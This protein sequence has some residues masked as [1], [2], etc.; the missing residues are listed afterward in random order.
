MTTFDFGDGNG[1]VPAH[2]HP[3]GG[4]WVA[5][6]AIVT[7]TAYVGP[8]ARVYGKARVFGDAQVFGYAQVYDKARVYGDAQV[9]D[10]ARV[11]GDAQVFGYAIVK[12]TPPKVSRS[13]GYDFIIVPCSDGQ[14]RILAG[15]RYFTIDEAYDHWNSD[16]PYYDETMDILNFLVTRAKKIY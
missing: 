13:D 7:D 5:D 11:F 2:K 15:C 8:D 16:H 1:H 6:T 12:I 3:I 9:Y 4:G 10:K 14:L